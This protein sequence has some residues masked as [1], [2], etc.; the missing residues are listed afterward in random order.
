[1]NIT[2]ENIDAL[3]AIVKVKVEKQDYEEK[4]DQVL[5]DYRKKANIKGFRPGMA[6]I[7]MVKKLYGKSILLD[8][9]NKLVSESLTNHIVE[10]KL[11]ILGEPLPS[12]HQPSDIDIENRE[13]FTFSFDIAMNPSIDL[14][15]SK[16][17]KITYYEIVV[18]DQMVN[19]TIEN[20]KSRF[21]TTSDGEIVEEKDLVKGTFEQLDQ[22]GAILEGGLKTEDS[23]FAVDRI[24]ES[25]I[26]ALVLG[27]K[28]GDI[29]DFDIKKAF[30]NTTDLSSMLRISKDDA[31][32]LAGNFRFT[33]QSITSYKPAEVGQ[34]LFDQ[35]Y[36][37]GVVSDET[38][39]RAKIVDEIKESFVS[40]SDYKFL[41]DVK[42]KLVEKANVTLPD[43]F[44]KRWLVAVNKELTKESV[45]KDY[46]LMKSDLA[47]QLIKNKMVDEQ[48]FKVEENELI[49]FAKKSVLMQFQQYGL[50][51]IPDEHLESYARKSLE[52]K[53]ERTKMIDRIFEQKIINY[54]KETMKVEPKG[55]TMKE[56]E[57]LFK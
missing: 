24:E 38:A 51:H 49:D 47:W 39:Y 41:L 50:M 11:D 31:E 17:D 3:N 37:E 14:K 25:N 10:E 9:I 56:F 6:P 8:E 7:G 27:A 29:I 22:D 5:K 16:R 57:G 54:L 12:I 53:D 20:H 15:L 52:K 19:E 23:L 44:L 40:S 2:R 42:E 35:V 46:P 21:G 48:Q 30:S 34:D 55:V 32:Q 4:V 33:I 1:M 26:R 45:E 36:G 43:E 28:N 13:E 18:D